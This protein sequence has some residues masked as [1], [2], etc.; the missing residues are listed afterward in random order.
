M[1]G[2]GDGNQDMYGL[3]LHQGLAVG[4]VRLDLTPSTSETGNL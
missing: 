2:V 4:E 1:G 3:L